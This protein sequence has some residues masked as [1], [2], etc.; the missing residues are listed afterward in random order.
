VFN[1]EGSIVQGK[2][3][4][5]GAADRAGRAQQAGQA[6]PGVSAGSALLGRMTTQHEA[7]RAAAAYKLELHGKEPPT[8]APAW[9]D[10]AAAFMRWVR[11]SK[12]RWPAAHRQAAGAQLGG[13]M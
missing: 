10:S 2:Q 7:L 3:C 5:Q 1:S 13:Y 6:A 8:C 9:P 11:Q 4:K 12:R